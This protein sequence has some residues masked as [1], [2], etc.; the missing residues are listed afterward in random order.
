M[1]VKASC[2]PEDQSCIIA[3]PC[4]TEVRQAPPGGPL[5]GILRRG[6]G[7]ISEFVGR[8]KEDETIAKARTMALISFMMTSARA[9]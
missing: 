5:N 4:S 6:S 2:S 9:G 3:H 8:G 7:A 1:K